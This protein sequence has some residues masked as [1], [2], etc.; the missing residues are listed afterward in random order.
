MGWDKYIDSIDENNN[1]IIKNT[2]STIIE[3]QWFKDTSFTQQ[4]MLD[5]IEGNVTKYKGNY[6]GF[7][8]K[9]NNFSWT[10]NSDNTYDITINLITIGSVIESLQVI[11]PTSPI[12]KARLEARKQALRK[13]YQIKEVE[14]GE[15][16][17][18]NSVITNLGSDRLS[19]FIAN[20]IEVFPYSLTPGFNQLGNSSY[21]NLILLI[22]SKAV[23]SLL[24]TIS[25]R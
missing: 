8:G 22:I 17:E 23:P 9:V 14:P 4:S 20:T 3:N 7:F 19:S 12:S 6:Q 18:T 21:A 15:N 24:A 1:P 2:E 5:L 16:P 25:I 13:H 10:L 11:V